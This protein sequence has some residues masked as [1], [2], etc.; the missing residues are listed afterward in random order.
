MAMRRIALG[1]V[2]FGVLY[3]RS[4]GPS[5]V[6]ATPVAG[7]SA[8]PTFAS[9][10]PLSQSPAP[11]SSYQPGPDA[12]GGIVVRVVPTGVVIDV[13]GRETEVDL[14]SVIDVWKETSV[15]ASAIELNDEL[16]LNGF[17][18][19]G[20]V[21]RYV[22]V[23]IGRLDGVIRSVDGRDIVVLASVRSGKENFATREVRVRLSTYLDV[24]RPAPGG[25]VPGSRAD[26]AVGREVGMVLYRPQSDLP[27]ATRIWVSLGT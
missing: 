18:G 5:P 15:P 23:N 14:R 27:R 21:A 22:W 12:L 7:P 2:V 25:M 20:F 11:T 4:A 10:P 1:A 9:S 26:L 17:A 3:L 6:S 24:V 16:S 13:G 8:I 19:D